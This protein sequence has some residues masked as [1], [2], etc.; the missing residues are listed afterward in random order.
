[1]DVL[2]R[3]RWLDFEDLYVR[4][5]NRFL[6]N[7]HV[8]EERLLACCGDT[9]RTRSGSSDESIESHVHRRFVADGIV[10][11]GLVILQCL[12]LEHPRDDSAPSDFLCN[13]GI[14]TINRHQLLD[15]SRAQWTRQVVEVLER[16][17]FVLVS[18]LPC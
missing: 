14:S 11:P 18:C 2:E 10:R 15:E 1:M 4:H 16:R 12:S 5:H 9:L 13:V 7:G 17:R 3:G 8:V 6:D